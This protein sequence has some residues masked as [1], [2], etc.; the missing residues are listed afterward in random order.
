MRPLLP[1]V[2]AALLAPLLPVLAAA[3]A[4]AAN[5]QDPRMVERTT[6]YTCASEVLGSGDFETFVRVQLPRTVTAGKKMAARPIDFSIVV[7]EEMTQ[8]M[9]DYGVEEVSGRSDDA[10]YK[11]GTKKRKIRRLELPSTEVPAEG[12]LVLEGTG[13]A[14]AVRLKKIDTYPVKLP[15]RFTATIT[16][17]G[18]FSMS[19]E[20][21]C[22]IAKGAKT[23]I[24][25]VRVV[26]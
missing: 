5:D 18:S 4:G 26:P 11:V 20:L 7:P 24:G 6:V 14:Q 17:T 16:V 1:A 13:T 3:P 12:L 22:R 15:G 9:R 2:A 10:T 23:K 21:T 8:T 19:D 25:S